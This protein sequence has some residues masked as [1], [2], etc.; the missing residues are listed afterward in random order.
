M[1]Q[2]YAI[3]NSPGFRAIF[4]NHSFIL[5]YLI[6]NHIYICVGSTVSGKILMLEVSNFDVV[7]SWFLFIFSTFSK[8]KSL[9]C[10][11]VR[12]LILCARVCCVCLFIFFHMNFVLSIVREAD[13]IVPFVRTHW[14]ARIFSSVSICGLFIFILGALHPS[15]VSFFCHRNIVIFI[16][17]LTHFSMLLLFLPASSF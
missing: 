5:S 14:Q 16:F 3:S 15:I 11:C 6:S 10:V 4:V 2:K 9:T 12:G 7:F 1:S 8:W 17:I 13:V